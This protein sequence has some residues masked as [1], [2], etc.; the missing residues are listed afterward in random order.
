MEELDLAVNQEVGLMSTW[1]FAR[2][3]TYIRGVRDR[4]VDTSASLVS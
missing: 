3:S 2:Y 4:L 1:T